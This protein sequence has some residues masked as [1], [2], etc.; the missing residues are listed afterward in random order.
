MLELRDAGRRFGTHR[1]FSGL[2]LDVPAGMRLLVAG[3]NG[4]GK[5]TLLRC[6]SGTLALS[7]GR[8]TVSGLRVG[9]LAARRLVGVCLAAEHGL[10]GTLSAHDNLMLV[11]RLRLPLHR[12]VGAVAQVER[13]LDIERFAG[14]PVQHCSAGM[15]AKVTIGRALIGEPALLLLDEPSRSLDD[16]GRGLLWD[17]LDRRPQVACVMASHHD[18]DRTRCHDVLTLPVQR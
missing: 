8:G 17:A 1:I 12:V 7:A 6:L 14:E 3:G 2:D 10:Y 13:E 4:S 9:S 15:R 18:D 5:T 11:A 16:R